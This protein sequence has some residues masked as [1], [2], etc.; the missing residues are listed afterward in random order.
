VSE[1]AGSFT[2]TV[3]DDQDLAVDRDELVRVSL[4]AL[5]ELSVEGGAQLAI[6][7]ATP[8]RM[9]ELKESA[10]GERAPT[11]VLAFPIDGAGERSPGPF[12]VGDV[13]LCPAV[14]RAQA[15]EAGRAESDEIAHLLVHGILHCLGRDH[16]EPDDEAS[17]RA[18]ER[19]I[20]AAAGR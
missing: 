15:A 13:V 14:A 3:D 1:R 2:V 4:R 6:T 16:A 20:L 7:L 11:D 18:E 19:L 17:M 9:A 12:V 10:L 5:T 8:E